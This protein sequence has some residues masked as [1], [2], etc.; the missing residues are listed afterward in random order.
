VPLEKFGWK[1]T[2]LCLEPT[3]KTLC[4]F[5]FV[6]QVQWSS[7]LGLKG[8][9]VLVI[10]GLAGGVVEGVWEVCPSMLQGPTHDASAL[11]VL[12]ETTDW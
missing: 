11:V 3:S 5:S 4:D 7:P 1:S 12:P 8:E 10:V 9:C 6:F 2:D